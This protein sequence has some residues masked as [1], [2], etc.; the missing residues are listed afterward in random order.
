MSSYFEKFPNTFYNFGNEET[1]T[2]FQNI[3]KYSELIDTYRDQIG[4]YISYEIRDGDRPDTVSQMLYGRPDYDWTF[5]IMNERL[6]ESGWPLTISQVYERA[7]NDYFPNYTARL[8]ITTADSASEYS[9]I[10]PVGQSVLVSGVEGVVISKN[11]DIGEITLSSSTSMIG[12]VNLSYSALEQ[13]ATKPL[14]VNAPVSMVYQYEGYHHYID[15]STEEYTDRFFDASV[16]VPVTNLEHLI[17]ENQNS[18]SIR[19][20]KKDLIRD[21]VG[22]YKKIISS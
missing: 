11:L 3:Q 4:T 16:K 19:V 21:V 20:I 18:K 7:V 12:G 22:K 2:V 13:D 17:N 5:Y 6:R 9:D 14:T 8:N 10:Y 1:P 15:A